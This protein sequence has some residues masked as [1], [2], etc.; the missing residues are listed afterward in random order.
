MADL[1]GGNLSKK[2]GQHLRKLLEIFSS[3]GNT[4]QQG[5]AVSYNAKE[6]VRSLAE[7]AKGLYPMAP[8]RKKLHSTSMRALVQLRH[9]WRVHKLALLCGDPVVWLVQRICW[10]S[11]GEAEGNCDRGESKHTSLLGFYQGTV[12]L[13][14]D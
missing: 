7:S 3:A 8:S 13:E 5:P 1:R 12:I 14:T 4:L 9:P 2:Q 10:Q 11:V 6:S